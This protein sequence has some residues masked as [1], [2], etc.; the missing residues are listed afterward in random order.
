MASEAKGLVETPA[1]EVKGRRGIKKGCEV[2]GYRCRDRK[3][4]ARTSAVR[5]L[6]GQRREVDFRLR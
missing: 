1:E 3:V 5:C 6:R 2:S 4:N